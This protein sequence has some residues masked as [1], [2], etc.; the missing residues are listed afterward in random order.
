[1]TKIT[2]VLKEHFDTIP[3]TNTWAL[4]HA[5][6]LMDGMLI[7]TTADEQTDG[8]GRFSH[9]WQAPKGLNLYVTYSYLIDKNRPDIG[10]IP[11]IMAIS[12]AKTLSSFKVTPTLKWPN[13]ILINNKKIAGILGETTFIPSNPDKLCMILGI[14]INVNMPTE[15][16]A[17]LG[18]PATSLCLETGKLESV[19]LTLNSL[20]RNFFD[21]LSV[22][23]KEGFS[24]FVTSYREQMALK[25]GDPISFHVNGTK[26]NGS[27]F[28]ITDKGSLRLCQSDGIITEF[29]SGELDFQKKL[30]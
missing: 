16:L 22:F 3:S 23:L 26:L 30:K 18:R 9:R 1:M 15:S 6:R 4:Q 8:R 27:F 13:D 28:D 2:E 5:N 7:Q 10:N 21:D 29:V 17:E 19:E 11:Q 12:A 25:K 20:E 14:G 24:P